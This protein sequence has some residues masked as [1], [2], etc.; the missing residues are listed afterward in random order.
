MEATHI[1][2]NVSSPAGPYPVHIGSGLLAEVPVLME[3][4][5]L[6]GRAAVV[7]N[8]TVGPLYAG[9]VVGSLPDAFLVT[10]PDGEQY[11]TL[12]SVETLYQAFVE[13]RLGRSGMVVALGG[14]VIGDTAGFAAA[15]YMRG[16]PLVML[17]TSLLSMVDS[18]VGGKVG[19]DLPH[20]KNLVG[21][22]KQP[23]LVVI[24]TATLDTLPA[25]EFRAGLA[26]V[27]KAAL[28]ADAGLLEMLE[29]HGPNPLAEVIGR[30]LA[31]KIGVVERDPFEQGERAHLNLGHTFAHAIEAATDYTAYRHGE[32]VAIGLAAAARLS[33]RLG[34]CDPALIGRTEALLGKLGL[35]TRSPGLDPADLWARMATDKKWRGALPTFVLLEG[36]GRP[37]TARGL[38]WGDVLPALEEMTS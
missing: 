38:S 19:V 12:R 34:R 4:C 24:D 21:A 26:E 7:S 11:K 18:S 6:R 25:V 30:A 22:F 10:L 1:T 8:V 20:G 2:L 29:Q 16:V 28:L 3:E 32:A 17:P 33:V 31:V 9:R 15:T 14:G 35:P 36:V 5:G 13:N 37:A 23:S 27:V